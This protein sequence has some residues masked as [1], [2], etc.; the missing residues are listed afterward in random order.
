MSLT[1]ANGQETIQRQHATACWKRTPSSYATSWSTAGACSRPP[2]IRSFY[3]GAALS[4]CLILSNLMHL[5]AVTDNQAA[6]EQLKDAEK[7]SHR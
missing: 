4:D 2:N 6:S 1:F 7:G 5:A 3:T